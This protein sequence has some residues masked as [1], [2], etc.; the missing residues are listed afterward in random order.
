MY[1][2]GKGFGLAAC[3]FSASAAVP[4]MPYLRIFRVVARPRR[5]VI[6]VEGWTST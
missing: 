5:K 1:R 2:S 4:R 3:I 6:P